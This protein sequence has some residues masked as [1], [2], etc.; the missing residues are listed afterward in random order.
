MFARWRT[1]AAAGAMWA[2]YSLSS[3]ATPCDNPE[4]VPVSI[5]ACRLGPEGPTA[6]PIYE[7]EYW[8]ERY[9]RNYW[10]DAA[11]DANNQ[12]APTAEPPATTEDPTTEDQDNTTP[13]TPSEESAVDAN[14]QC[15][16]LTCPCHDAIDLD[17]DLTAE[18]QRSL[19]D[20]SASSPADDNTNLDGNVDSA[21]AIDSTGRCGDWSCPCHDLINLDLTD[22]QVNLTPDAEGLDSAGESDAAIQL[23]ESLDSTECLEPCDGST[24]PCHGILN[25]SPADEATD[26]TTE[27]TEPD[28]PAN[29]Q[30]IV[31]EPAPSTNVEIYEPY[32]YR[33]T[34][35]GAEYAADEY[36]YGQTG[37]PIPAFDSEDARM[38]DEAGPLGQQELDDINVRND[39][40]DD[41]P[42]TATEAQLSGVIE[43]ETDVAGD[44]RT[45]PEISEGEKAV[46]SQ[47]ADANDGFDAEMIQDEAS[48]EATASQNAESNDGADAE[49]IQDET[50]DEAANSNESAT[51]E[52][53]S[54]SEETSTVPS[55][56]LHMF[57][58][59]CDW[60]PYYPSHDAPNSDAIDESFESTQ[61]TSVRVS[62][63]PFPG[64][65]WISQAAASVVTWTGK[66]AEQVGN[67][68]SESTL[69][70]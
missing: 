3:Q 25:D 69:N 70:D 46:P 48:D 49:M 66:L 6:Q 13:T 42:A 28:Y 67:L 51:D 53:A 35:N 11:S 33:S 2:S 10:G 1:L 68:I 38:I 37:D 7:N 56:R 55:P 21:D 45:E 20:Q 5:C 50:S 19:E 18:E 62:V 9:Y 15:G 40:I 44:A 52:Q 58:P 27:I 63:A 23:N 22:D 32:S 57:Y 14:G 16:D 17:A 43:P 26:Q 65:I 31:E 60:S 64:S 29:W 4:S 24:C 34:Q 54:Q 47:D 36:G 30:N 12:E 41:G 59:G 8:Y 39:G 61:P